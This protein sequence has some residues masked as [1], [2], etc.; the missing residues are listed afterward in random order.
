MTRVRDIKY[1]YRG[2]LERYLVDDGDDGSGT[3][4]VNH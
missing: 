1:A 3:G 4:G 2:T